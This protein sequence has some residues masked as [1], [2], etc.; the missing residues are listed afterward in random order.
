MD[1]VYL[2]LFG[3]PTAHR[4]GAPVTFRTRKTFALLIYLAVERQPV[5]RDQLAALLWPESD[6]AHARGMLRNTLVYLRQA[7][8]DATLRISRETVGLTPGFDVELD[9]DAV[10]A[11]ADTASLVRQRDATVEAGSLHKI[12][13]QFHDAVSRYHGDFLAGF[14]LGDA[15]DF[16]NWAATGRELWHQRVH[17]IFDRLT[18]L[19]IDSG[20]LAGALETA[21][22]W[23]A[24]DRLSEEAR[25][26]Q[27]GLL[28]AAGDRAAALR[29]YDA[30][31]EVLAA[32]LDAQP[33]PATVQLISGLQHDSER[34]QPADRTLRPDVP[35]RPDLTNLT[36]MVGRADDVRAL[37]EAMHRAEYGQPQVVVV[38]GEAGIG[39]TRLVTAW[40][41]WATA[42]GIDVLVGRA[43]ETS[44]QL[45]YGPLVD[46]LRDRIDR[47]RAPDDLLSDVWLTELSRLFPELR[48]RY[49]DLAAPSGDETTARLRLFESLTRLVHA[50]AVR[51]PV[52]LIIDDAHWADTATLDWVSYAARQ[53][54]EQSTRLLLLISLRDDALRDRPFRAPG[55]PDVSA[56]LAGLAR[57]LPAH[58]VAL[59]PLSAEA[60]RELAQAVTGGWSF[61]ETDRFSGWLFGETGGQP[62]YLSE[63]LVL[64]CEQGFVTPRQRADGSWRL[65]LSSP[66]CNLEAL[67]GLVPATVRDMIRTRLAHLTPQAFNLLAAGAVLGR[68]FGF[69]QLC[70]VAALGDND[71]LAVLD[72]LIQANLLQETRRDRRQL[73][74]IT[75]NVAHDKIREVIYTEIG[76]TRRRVFHQRAL[77]ELQEA[78]ADPAT[79]AHHA[80]AAGLL[81]PALQYSQAAGDAAMH[82]FA[83]Q[84]AI[85]HYERVR[86]LLDEQPDLGSPPVDLPHLYL[87]L[88]RAYELMNDSPQAQAVYKQLQ[89]LAQ[90]SVDTSL[91]CVALNRL[92]TVTMQDSLQVDL[93]LKLLQHALALAT[94][95]RDQ[96]GLAETEWNLAQLHAYI[97]QEPVALEHGTRALELARAHGLA[98]LAA[99][100]LNI[101]AYSLAALGRWDEMDIYAEEARTAFVALGNQA[102]TGDCV[103]LLASSRLIQ[104]DPTNGI[105]LAQEAYTLSLETANVWG[106][107]A[108]GWHLAIG[109]A[110]QGAYDAALEV[111]RRGVALART[112][113]LPTMLVLSLVVLGDV[114]RVLLALAEARTAHL[115]ALAINQSIAHQPFTETVAAALCADYALAGDDELAGTYARQAHAARGATTYLFSDLVRH[116]EIAALAQSGD[117]PAA[118]ESLRRFNMRIGANQRLRIPYLRAQAAL[119]QQ[120]GNCAAAIASL[121]AAAG[122]ATAL[123][124]PGERWLAQAALARCYTLAGHAHRAA[125]AFADAE[126]I[127]RALAEGIGD[128]QRRAAFLDA[129]Q[130]GLPYS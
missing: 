67:H 73:T 62:F 128:P 38:A 37:T 118:E 25:R 99:R 36:P 16:D 105:A 21:T 24:H 55:Q 123:D 20:N 60:I 58:R 122:V 106:Q 63:L 54:A 83:A 8:G 94:E 108:S 44:S 112:L 81:E 115:E 97:H 70:R 7:L 45:P 116:Y 26:R 69:V 90:A 22:R 88:G 79:L 71:G 103:S 61:D 51:T 52:A 119:T 120:D 85:G 57:R 91:E 121:C 111:A 19:Q 126:R 129:A 95:S 39:K 125:E 114:Q 100:C 87:Q 40:A 49:P 84:D 80:L 76:D 15:P 31:R 93:A 2:T 18:Q 113:P 65:D 1:R 17:S 3:T 59:A 130:N 78:Q 86:Q 27:I 68:Q 23:V 13:Q 53:W 9:L 34:W 28:A 127:T 12:E 64:L 42:R 30:W 92:A 124:L 98:D 72:D 102:L 10:Q 32:E 82:L 101:L 48:D 77:A 29:A 35:A 33:A 43:F 5:A 74:T 109:Q 110:E 89:N 75:Y 117:R 4:G 14:A 104:G 47:E 11:A 96:A 46:A 50:L 6:S 107:V 66:I 56:W 41:N